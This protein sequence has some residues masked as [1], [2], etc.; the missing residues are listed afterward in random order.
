MRNRSTHTSL[1]LILALA[2]FTLAAAVPPVDRCK[3]HK[4][5]IPDPGTL[6]LADGEHVIA[7]VDTENGKFEA[8][9]SVK[10]KVASK[11][12][13][14]IGGKLLNPARESE[15]PKEFRDCLKEAQRS[16]SASRSPLENPAHGALAWL[17][18]AASAAVSCRAWATCGKAING[19]YYCVGEVCC[20]GHPC[21]WFY[22]LE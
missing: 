16:A 7:S 13:F 6:K 15:I 3:A 14:Y 17:P 2:C 9:V 4:L 12:R 20:T 11:P 1:L 8:R 5:E 21:E 10:N 19:R 22:S 18:P